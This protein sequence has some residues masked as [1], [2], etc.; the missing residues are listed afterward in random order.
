MG[1]SNDDLHQGAE[2]LLLL[3]ITK[4]ITEI[5]TKNQSWK[6]ALLI[7]NKQSLRQTSTQ[8]NKLKPSSTLIPYAIKYIS[9]QSRALCLHIMQVRISPAYLFKL[10]SSLLSTK[11]SKNQ[12]TNRKTETK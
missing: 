7:D 1:T 5:H 12:E 10:G 6:Y 4:T 3:A 11:Q 8:I 2:N 9:Y